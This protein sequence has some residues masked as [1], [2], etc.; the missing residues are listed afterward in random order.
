MKEFRFFT[1]LT[2]WILAVLIV[3]IMIVSLFEYYLAP[4]LL[5]VL[6]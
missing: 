1:C 6:T 5:R 2:I 3:V 4:L